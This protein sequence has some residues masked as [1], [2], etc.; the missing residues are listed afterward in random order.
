MTVK[1]VIEGNEHVIELT[2]AELS[3]AFFEQQAIFDRYDIEDELNAYED[4][5]IKLYYGLDRNTLTSLIDDMACRMRRY[6]DKYEYD[7]HSARDE[8]IR[9]VASEYKERH[10]F[11]I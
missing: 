5:E 8:A 6:I 9:D 3:D 4:K 7:W 2:K 11:V 10:G 1:R